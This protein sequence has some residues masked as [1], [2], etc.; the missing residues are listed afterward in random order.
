MVGAG[1]PGSGRSRG[2]GVAVLAGRRS[3][4]LLLLTA[5]AGVVVVAA[6]F[7]LLQQRGVL[8]WGALAIGVAAPV[9]VFAI[10]I[11]A[12]LLWVD[13]VAVVMLGASVFAARTALRPERSAWVLP[14]VGMPAAET[15]AS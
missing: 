11:T 13:V 12:G 8:R 1:Q 5:A 14:V 10:L 15:E 3:V 6:G 9:V 2:R 7:W 4:W